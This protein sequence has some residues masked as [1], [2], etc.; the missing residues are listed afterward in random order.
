MTKHPLPSEIWGKIDRVAGVNCCFVSKGE[1]CSGYHPQGTCVIYGYEAL[2][3]A[4][5]G[6]IHAARNGALDEAIDEIS[7]LLTADGLILKPEV[8]EILNG[9][10]WPNW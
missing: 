7:K 10:K 1:K 3:A 4:V 5:K 9:L 2:S 8:L 6:A